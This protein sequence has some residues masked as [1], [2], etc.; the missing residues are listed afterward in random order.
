MG[1]GGAASAR[2]TR[3]RPCAT[4]LGS[5]ANERAGLYLKYPNT[6]DD[7]WTRRIVDFHIDLLRL[8][9]RALDQ[10]GTCRNVMT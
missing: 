8:V 2:V 1:I 9:P 5:E 3:N 10:P 7:A 4:L 6:D